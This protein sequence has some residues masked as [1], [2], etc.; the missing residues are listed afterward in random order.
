MPATSP[1]AIAN[2]KRIRKARERKASAAKRIQIVKS[3]LPCYKISARRMLP[4]LPLNI[5][6]AELREM[7]AQAAANTA[8]D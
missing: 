7:I 5:T 2:K 4:R 1:K 6:K 8:A 3:D